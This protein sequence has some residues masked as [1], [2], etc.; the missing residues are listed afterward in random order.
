MKKQITGVLLVLC[1]YLTLL[2]GTAFAETPSAE[3]ADFTTG[4]GTAAISLLNEAKTSG[5]AD[6]TWDNS[7]K[8]LTLKGMDFSTTATTALKLP[9]GATIVLADGTVNTITGGDTTVETNRE[10]GSLSSISITAIDALGDLTI[11]GGAA[12]TGIL[13]V[14]SGTHT[15]TGNAWTYSSAI[16]VNGNFTVLGG[17]ITARGGTAYSADCAFSTGVLMDDIRINKNL[18]VIGGTLTAIG[19]ESF[20]TGETAGKSFSHGVS[21]YKGGISVTGNGKLTAKCDPAMD[22]EGLAFA[23]DISSGDLL[24]SEEGEVAA[25][26]SHGIDIHA[27]GIKLTGG[28]ITAVRA[29][30]NNSDIG[31][32]ISVAK[33]SYA[34]NTP[35][36]GSIVITDG[37]LTAADGN[38]GLYA[39][40]PS[41]TQGVFTMTDGTVRIEDLYGADRYQISGGTIQTRRISGGELTLSDAALTIRE[42]VHQISTG[43]LY[44]SSALVLKKLTVNSGTLDAAWD[45]GNYTPIVFPEDPYDGFSTPLIEVWGDS[46][47]IAAFNGGTA[48]FDTGCAGNIVLKSERIQLGDGMVETGA[49]ST[50]TNAHTQADGSTPVVFS[51]FRPTA[52]TVTGITAGDKTYDGTTAAAL[53]GGTLSGVT[54]GDAD[55]VAL[56]FSDVTAAFADKN[57]ANGKRVTVTGNLRLSGSSAYRYTLT[58]P[59][60][61]D[62]TANILP[63]TAVT[64]VTSKNQTILVGTGTFTAPR[65]TGVTVGEKAENADGDVSYTWNNETKTAE[66]VTAALKALKA[67]ESLSIGYTFTGTGNY[68]GASGSGE[69]TIRAQKHSSGGHTSSHSVTDGKP[70]NPDPSADDNPPLPFFVDVQAGDYFYDAVLWATK[71][72]ITSGTDALRFSPGAPCTRAQI[73][74]FLWRAAGSPEPKQAHRFTDVS[75]NSYYAKAVAW[76]VGNGITGGTSG[77][78]F[79][80]DVACTRAQAAAFLWREAGSPEPKNAASFTDVATD[81]YYAKAVAWAMEN[82]ITDGMS[83]TTFSPDAYCTRAQIVTFLYRGAQTK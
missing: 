45:W 7:S 58:P 43:S 32:A 15:N 16:T 13:S 5:A 55:A 46:S 79:S 67:G 38:V 69:I 39:Y 51:A 44:A 2:S 24:V 62:L 27:G 42:P 28:K 63:C 77:T 6:S 75:L 25:T 59:D 31:N 37:T 76:A 82:G 9:A 52:V 18:S 80:P 19:G 23:L 8:T 60:L 78:A 64:D 74:T 3:T 81:N 1:L 72:G 14:T 10:S 4:S 61:T 35:N 36:A 33:N 71:K 26:A 34:A 68:A 29:K 22:G 56:D 20:D 17:H 83:G 53:T 40:E 70:E 30:K 12:G 48:K 49:E 50:N 54:A 66:E 47:Y 41:D 65:F 11:R 21:I 73:V 57:A